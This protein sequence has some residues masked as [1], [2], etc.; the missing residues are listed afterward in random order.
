MSKEKNIVTERY[1]ISSNNF[2]KEKNKENMYQTRTKKVETFKSQKYKYKFYYNNTENQKTI[3]EKR[4]ASNIN[5][6]EINN[7]TDENINIINIK[8]NNCN[9]S[10]KNYLIENSKNNNI[11]EKKYISNLKYQSKYFSK[12]SNVNNVNYSNVVNV[13]SK[14]SSGLSN[15]VKFLKKNI[16][17]NSKSNIYNSENISPKKLKP[18]CE[19]NYSINQITNVKYVNG[20]NKKMSKNNYKRFPDILF[21]SK[22]KSKETIQS[23]GNDN[24]IEKELSTQC[25]CDINSKCTCGKRRYNNEMNYYLNENKDL[26]NHIKTINVE[27]YPVIFSE[28]ENTNLKSKKHK[29]IINRND[30]TNLNIFKSVD[31]VR[32]ERF[33]KTKIKNTSDL[34]NS[35]ICQCSDKNYSSTKKNHIFKS[36]CDCS[37]KNIK[38]NMNTISSKFNEVNDLKKNNI[39]IKVKKGMNRSTSYENYKNKNSSK[40][41]SEEYNH[42]F[43]EKNNKSFDEEELRMQNIQNLNIIQDKKFYQIIVPLQENKI[44]YQCGIE[45]IRKSQKKYTLEEIDEI[46]KNEKSYN[47]SESLTSKK[48]SII[49]NNWNETNEVV[50]TNKISL[51]KTKKAIEDELDLD[52]IIEKPQQLN[53]EAFSININDEGRRFK[54]EMFAENISIEYTN[55]NK[56]KI[57]NPNY[58]LSLAKSEEILLNAD[59]P[60][61]DWNNLTKPIRGKNISFENNNHKLSL[62]GENIERILIKGSEQPKKDWNIYNNEKKEVNI[63]LCQPKKSQKLSKQRLKPLLIKGEETNNKI[64]PKDNESKIIIKGLQIRNKKI[65][66][67]KESKLVINNDNNNIKENYNRPIVTNI[68]KVQEISEESISSEID[69]LKNIKKYNKQINLNNGSGMDKEKLT[70]KREIKIII[71][72]ISKKFPK[73]VETYHGDDNIENKEEEQVEII[74]N[75]NINNN[76]NSGQIQQNEKQINLYSKKIISNNYVQSNSKVIVQLEKNQESINQVRQFYCKENIKL[77]SENGK[78]INNVKLYEKNDI[79]NNDTNQFIKD[80]AYNKEIKYKQETIENLTPIKSE[81]PEDAIH[82]INSNCSINLE[83]NENN[84][85]QNYEENINKQKIIIS[86]DNQNEK[87]N[88]KPMQFQQEYTHFNNIEQK[89]PSI[90]YDDEDNKDNFN[91]Y[92]YNEMINEQNHAQ[93]QIQYIYRKDINKKYIKQIIKNQEKNEEDKNKNIINNIN[94]QKSEIKEYGQQFQ[95]KQT[96]YDLNYPEQEQEN[97]LTLEESKHF[98]NAQNQEIAQENYINIK[99]N[100]GIYGQLQEIE[101]NKDINV[102]KYINADEDITNYNL[103]QQLEISKTQELI[104]EEP[105]PPSQIQNSNKYSDFIQGFSHHLKTTPSDNYNKFA[106]N[107]LNI[108]PLQA[109]RNDDNK[110]QL[111]S[112]LTENQ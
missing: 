111:F 101:S 11:K 51:E 48:F 80:Q 44:D 98:I 49:L 73:R 78:N 32:Y 12:K 50:N 79:N 99:S 39:Y 37:K 100:E 43:H 1:N 36:I 7:F 66:K 15:G 57:K 96:N 16:S 20:T 53:I 4:N 94:S 61:K 84:K 22:E 21:K 9:L 54:G 77:S 90:L 5:S 52:K 108:I 33:A 55:Q 64:N 18:N 93:P 14:Y 109:N 34:N 68:K 81:R 110:N 63:N 76:T 47:Q 38:L 103:Q 45:I 72:D 29:I 56:N 86:N 102:N 88:I 75:Q 85:K 87:L 13:T 41:S 8:N 104:E 91:N 40:C 19:T 24:I 26:N 97:L 95:I 28:D 65:E 70:D 59:Y 58:N 25:L 83:I 62:I 106:I 82:K 67:D 112:N 74:K 71:N 10:D 89:I 60:K 3:K 92:N 69:V 2:I 23:D 17:E 30:K 46:L 42:Y 105:M 35:N 31:N 107:K 27:T 6:N